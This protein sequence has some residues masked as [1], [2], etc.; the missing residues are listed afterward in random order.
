MF[1]RHGHGIQTSRFVRF[2]WVILFPIIILSVAKAQSPRV[3]S[4]QKINKLVPEKIKGY[5]IRGESKSSQVSIGNITYSM[6]ERTFASGD[7]TVKILMFDYADASVMFD[8]A[9]KKWG[10]VPQQESDSIIFRSFTRSPAEGWESYTTGNKHSQ[11]IL[12]ISD[13]FFLTLSGEKME[14]VELRKFL[15][16]FAF[17]KFPDKK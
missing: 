1:Y 5:H 8:Q 4:P 10:Q 13:R 9:M 3:L 15:D 6:C 14:L 17:E 16:Y 11:L 7:R 12:G 2:F